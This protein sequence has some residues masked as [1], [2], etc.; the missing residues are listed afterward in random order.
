MPSAQSTETVRVDWL[1]CYR[2]LFDA[3]KRW[4]FLIGGRGAGRSWAVAHKVTQDS[5]RQRQ[6]GACIRWTRVATKDSMR[7]D[8]GSAIRRMRLDGF[9]DLTKDGHVTGRNGSEIMFFGLNGQNG[10]R[11]LT[12]IDWFWLE[13]A[14]YLL[15][16]DFTQMIQTLIRKTGVRVYV[17]ANAQF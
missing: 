13:E 14:Q 1:P 2:P 16:P 11:S 5:T 3:S 7:A 9:W 4:H 6:R 10:L 12:D 17:T 8:I 15:D